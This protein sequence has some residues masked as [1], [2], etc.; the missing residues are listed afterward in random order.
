MRTAGQQIL[1]SE[2]Y[3]THQ[4]GISYL[5]GLLALVLLACLLLPALANAAGP[6]NQSGWLTSVDL[7][8]VWQGNAD[9]GD[10]GQFSVDRGVFEIGTARRIGEQWMIGLSLGYGEDQ[11]SFSD[12]LNGTPWEDI[13]SLQF[14]VTMRYQ[15]SDNWSLFGLPVLRYSAERDASLNDGREIGLLAGASYRFNDNLKIGPG[16]GVFNGIGGEEDVFPILLINWAITDE[17][18]LETGRGLAASRGP[19]LALKWQPSGRW[20][21]GLAAR[22]EK[23]RFRLADDR[24]RIAEDKAIPVVLTAAWKWNPTVSIT[25]LAGMENNGDLSIENADGERINRLSYDTA[26][27]LGVVAT[28]LF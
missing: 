18:S 5:P 13:R 6:P 7:A 2:L 9:L 14:G 1:N 26:P 16:L 22:Y 21:F 15:A 20:E 28:F 25:A 19:G 10:D 11:Y 23:F 8:Y 12:T 24:D 4:P 17:V 27:L 3:T